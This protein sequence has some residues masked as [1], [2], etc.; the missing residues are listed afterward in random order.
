MRLHQRLIIAEFARALGVLALV[1]LSFAH[2]PVGQ[3]GVDGLYLLPDGSVPVICGQLPQG[4]DRDKPSASNSCAVHQIGAGMAEPTPVAFI[5]I[6]H[7]VIAPTLPQLLPPPA[8]IAPLDRAAGP[9]AP[10]LV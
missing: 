2:Q 1:F 5:F 8:R 3:R 9:R 6:P 10:P 7:P 4:T